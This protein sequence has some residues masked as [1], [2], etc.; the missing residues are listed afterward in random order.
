MNEAVNDGGPAFPI[1]PVG[2]GDPR[3]GMT[4]GSDGMSLR[5][6]FAGQALVGI[7]TCFAGSSKLLPS[8]NIA[9]R[10]WE[11]ADAMLAEREK[12]KP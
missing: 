2:T 4:R 5:D 8:E 1:L 3:D 10:A 9:K 6:Y 12:S 7:L 11:N